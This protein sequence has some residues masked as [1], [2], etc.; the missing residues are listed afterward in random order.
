MP[1]RCHVKMAKSCS[2]HYR[3][4]HYGRNVVEN[5]A[6]A[7]LSISDEL[8]SC[9]S[10][11]LFVIICPRRSCVVSAAFA[12]DVFNAIIVSCC[13]RMVEC[14]LMALRISKSI[15]SISD[16]SSLNKKLMHLLTALAKN[17]QTVVGEIV[18]SLAKDSQKRMKGL[19]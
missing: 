3:L 7:I 17:G 10:L 5:K 19:S 1:H 18:K 6:T 4:S 15:T 14:V 12:L 2:T 9:L 13:F 11:S 8:V 16:N